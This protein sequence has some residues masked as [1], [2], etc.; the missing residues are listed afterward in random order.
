MRRNNFL[1]A[2]VVAIVT[3]ASLSA[4]VHRP[5]GWHRTWRYRH[6]YYDN[7]YDERNS[8]IKDSTNR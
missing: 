8:A 7:R 1:V 4:F 3:F 5:W 6:C 2:A